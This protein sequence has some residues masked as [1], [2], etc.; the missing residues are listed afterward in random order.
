VK[1]G[2]FGLREY[3]PAGAFSGDGPDRAELVPV[4]L[5]RCAR[6]YG[7]PFGLRETWIV[8]D[9]VHDVRAGRAG[10]VRCA[11]VATGNTPVGDLSAEAPDLL[12]ADL[13]DPRPLWVALEAAP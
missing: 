1:L 12:L 11:A 5:A 13:S 6:A 7:Q 2:F 9:S 8:G 3:F 4:A 10:G